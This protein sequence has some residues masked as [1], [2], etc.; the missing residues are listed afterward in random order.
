MFAMH[1]ITS[2]S[3]RKHDAFHRNFISSVLCT[4]ASPIWMLG[5]EE[6]KLGL[7]LCINLH[8]I[9]VKSRPFFQIDVDIDLMLLEQQ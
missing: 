9:S 1:H 3:Y 2:I 6:S 5:L 8:D 4:S 7:S